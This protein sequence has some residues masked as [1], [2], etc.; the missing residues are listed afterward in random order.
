MQKAFGKQQALALA[1]ALVS[2]P[3]GKSPVLG[4]GF[5]PEKHIFHT[6]TYTLL[7]KA[8]SLA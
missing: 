5:P 4:G 6:H 2:P 3:P 7:E 1:L 8:L